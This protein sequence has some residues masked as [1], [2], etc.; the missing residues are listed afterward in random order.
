[1]LPATR[2]PSRS[3]TLQLLFSVHVER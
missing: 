2:R 1:V 3:C